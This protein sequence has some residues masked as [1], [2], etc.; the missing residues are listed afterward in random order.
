[1]VSAT[2]FWQAAKFKKTVASIRTECEEPV[3]SKLDHILAY[4]TCLKRLSIELFP[5]FSR[6]INFSQNLAE[7]SITRLSSVFSALVVEIQQVIDA[8]N[9]S[10]TDNANEG[11]I[12]RLFQDSQTMLKE[13]INTFDTILQREF[14]M[15]EQVR[16]LAGFGSEMKKM[17]EGVRAVADQINLLALNVAIEAARAGE[18][19]R[20]FAV[21]AEEVRKLAAT[22]SDTGAQI[23]AKVEELNS[24]MSTTLALVED[25]MHTADDLVDSS[26][27]KVEGVLSRLKG[28]TDSL[29]ADTNKLRSL[30]QNI[31]AQISESLVNLQ[32][33]DRMS[34]ILN[35]VCEGLDRLSDG[36]KET[37]KKDI[38]QQHQDILEIDT[39]LEQML[40]S[41]STLEEHSLHQGS[42]A[43][44][45]QNEASELTFF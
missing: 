39:L 44:M 34:Q 41:Y 35:H 40:S 4:R 36:L 45:V 26:E 1:M 15:A 13:V 30:N 11:Q 32:F 20:G 31:S 25:A 28:T 42:E 27:K 8:S 37:V 19:G 17:A 5:V 16:A 29:H 3:E 14:A 7:E 18:H 23:S 21:V 12:I 10:T 38:N 24:S 43:Q 33:Q 9:A 2:G 6:N 22:S